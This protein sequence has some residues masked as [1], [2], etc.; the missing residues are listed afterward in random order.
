MKPRR[1]AAILL[2]L[3]VLAHP[4]LHAGVSLPASPQ[5]APAS[6]PEGSSQASSMGQCVTCRT[7]SSLVES[8][9][10]FAVWPPESPIEPLLASSPAYRSWRPLPAPSSRAP[11]LR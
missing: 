10:Q 1:V 2:L 3:H 4:A 6:L 11:P 8:H 5:A 7:G 9:I